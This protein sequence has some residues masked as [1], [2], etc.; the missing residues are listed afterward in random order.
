M[1]KRR[2]TGL[3]ASGLTSS[4]DFQRTAR[5]VSLPIVS[6][7]YASVYPGTGFP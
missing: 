4:S 3:P 7:A 1:T 5:S 2:R 6:T